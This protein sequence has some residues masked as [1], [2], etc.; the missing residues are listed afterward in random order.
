MR[1][2]EGRSWGKA[3][4]NEVLKFRKVIEFQ[5]SWDAVYFKTSRFIFLPCFNPSVQVKH[6]E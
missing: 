3:T 4:A 5:S 2:N 6:Q 1:N